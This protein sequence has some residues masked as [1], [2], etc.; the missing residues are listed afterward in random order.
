MNWWVF[1][2]VLF[3]AP[4]AVVGTY[5]SIWYFFYIADRHPWLGLLILLVISAVVAGLVIE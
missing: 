2:G 3:L 1:F 4:I 5:F